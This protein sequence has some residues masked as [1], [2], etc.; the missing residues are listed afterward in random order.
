MASVPSSN[1]ADTA[2]LDAFLSSLPP[3]APARRPAV[4][5]A[6]IVYALN[7]LRERAKPCSFKNSLMMSSTMFDDAFKQTETVH[8]GSYG[9]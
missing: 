8:H 3:P 4:A 5:L 7:A 2:L 9:G 1:G 6:D